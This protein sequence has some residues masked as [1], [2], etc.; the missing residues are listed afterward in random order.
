MK[1]HQLRLILTDLGESYGGG[2]RGEAAGLREFVEDVP[3]APVAVAN[4]CEEQIVL[5][6]EVVED[7][8]GGDARVFCDFV[9]RG[10]AK[11]AAAEHLDG[12]IDDRAAPL[13]APAIVSG[14]SRVAHGTH[15]APPAPLSGTIV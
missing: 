9:E 14:P 10:G 6:L 5:R 13:G 8:G 7:A 3:L 12:G 4:H 11:A 15:R 1:S 2:E